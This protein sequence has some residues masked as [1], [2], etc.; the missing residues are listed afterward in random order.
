VFEPNQDLLGELIISILKNPQ[1]LKKKNPQLFV[2][3]HIL[4]MCIS[5]VF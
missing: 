1:L 3:I 2:S 5:T 4:K